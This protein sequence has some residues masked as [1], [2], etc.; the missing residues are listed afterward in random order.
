M[1]HSEIWSNYS[2]VIISAPIR[3]E[4]LQH[5]RT[6]RIAPH[7]SR[8]TASFG[9]SPTSLCS[10]GSRLR[11]LIY[12][13]IFTSYPSSLQI[14]SY[15]PVYKGALLCRPKKSCF[16]PSILLNPYFT[17]F[18]LCS[19]CAHA[20]R[21]LSSGI[22]LLCLTYLTTATQYINGRPSTSL[23]SRSGIST[24]RINNVN[25]RPFAVAFSR[26]RLA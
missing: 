7:P 26:S 24:D 18:P 23:L 11:V 9:L 6:E 20:V 3:P 2:I 12:S 1:R 19:S 14:A 22:R 8:P 13:C 10:R 4:H 15:S 21:S 16:H 5:V 25:R 17:R